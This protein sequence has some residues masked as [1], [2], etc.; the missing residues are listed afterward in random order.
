MLL[1]GPLPLKGDAIGG[2]KV[3]F[4]A[5][6]DFF[7]R[8]LRFSVRVLNT[9]REERMTAGAGLRPED[10]GVFLR[11][12]AA[13]L[14]HRPRPDIVV[15]NIS[16]GA[17][18]LA[19]PPLWLVTRWRG[20][21]LV[22]RVFGGD[23]EASFN[24]AGAMTRW[25]AHRT[26]L[27]S[28]L[29]LLQTRSLVDWLSSRTNARWLPTTRDMPAVQMEEKPCR[30]LLFLGQLRREKGLKE[31]AETARAL[32]AHFSIT[33]AGP[34]VDP[35]VSNLLSSSSLRY[36][37]EVAPRDVP[38]LLAEH[39]LLLYPSYH[40]GEGYPGVVIEAMQCGVP[41]IAARWRSLPELVRDGE[42]GLLTKPGSASEL[43][44]AVTRIANDPGL[45]ARL[46]EGARRTGD[47]LRTPRILAELEQ[48]LAQI[49]GG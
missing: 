49:A 35:S 16:S 3:S 34:V 37:G 4:A 10:I 8:S 40:E 29:I 19:G 23:F 24:R 17:L 5:M 46:S 1:I 7:A 48:M 47:E 13:I 18:L 11:V 12:S 30:R 42:N 9:S 31:I 2:T 26:Y 44:A 43:T 27:R 25:L 28:A 21:P 14:L 33:I 22:L 15:L 36:V 41:V 39:D 38:R 6:A 20:A 45:Y 32:P